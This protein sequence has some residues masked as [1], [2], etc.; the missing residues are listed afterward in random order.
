MD[1]LIFNKQ[2]Y[3]NDSLISVN[4][5]PTTNF[6][7]ARKY[8]G[9]CNEFKLGKIM[10]YGTRAFNLINSISSKKF[11]ED[12]FKGAYTL[13]MKKKKLVS[14]I[15]ILKLSALRY[16]ILTENT[17][18]TLKFLNKVKRKFPL[19]TVNDVTQ[20]YTL[21]S[22]HGDK[23][24]NFL[25]MLKSQNLYKVKRQ[26]YQYYVFLS[27]KK[28]EIQVINY[29]KN[30]NFVPISLETKTLFL[31]NNNVI[32]NLDKIKRKMKKYV[33]DLTYKSNTFNYIKKDNP[34]EIKQ[35][36]LSDYAIPLKNTPIFYHKFFSC[37]KVWY[38]YK[39][40]NKKYP[41][42]L[43][44]VK[45]DKIGKKAILKDGKKEILLKQFINY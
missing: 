20:N 7:K 30:L 26:N 37:G 17:K 28:N 10:L 39:L 4:N 41:Y 45:K 29:F 44:I 34:F 33:Y 38:S 27:S 25:D 15:L 19:T 1:E 22:F 14:E 42:V 6:L 5:D 12:N 11:N 43:C 18:K 40:P 8:I 36:E 31:Y 16:L 3:Y 13:I 23:S 32:I 24:I 2:S 21:F 9:I 35:F